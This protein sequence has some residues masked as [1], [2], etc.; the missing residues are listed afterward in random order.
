M[1]DASRIHTHSLILLIPKIRIP[2][3]PNYTTLW[4][5]VATAVVALWLLPAALALAVLWLPLLC[6]AVA[7]PAS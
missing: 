2:K 4:R 5:A 1:P 7:P 6:Y 3:T